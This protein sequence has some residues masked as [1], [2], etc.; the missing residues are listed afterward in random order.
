MNGFWKIINKISPYMVIFYALKLLFCSI[1]QILPNIEKY[2]MSNIIDQED[3]NKM[4]G[5]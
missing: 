2:L 5:W 4:F 3:L 1:F